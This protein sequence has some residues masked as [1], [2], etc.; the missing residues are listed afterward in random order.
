MPVIE[1]IT[2]ALREREAVFAILIAACIAEPARATVLEYGAD[3]QVTVREHA[4]VTSASPTDD[5]IRMSNAGKERLRTLA[6][7]TALGHAGDD[8][9][10]QA[11]LD[12]ATFALLFEMLIQRESAFDPKAVSPKGARGLGQLMPGTA[13][14][15]GV[16]DPFDPIANLDGS[17]RYLV[18]QLDRFGSVELALAAYNAGPGAVAKHGGVP[19]FAETRAYV[20]WIT[21]RAGIEARQMP[22]AIADGP[23]SADTSVVPSP[24]ATDEREAGSASAPAIGFEDDTTFTRKVSVWEF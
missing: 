6:R 7:A 11:G 9:I 22:V 23:A 21:K 20:D 16:A 4:K 8:A 2:R 13:S 24:S 14:D 5:T 10:E 17:A 15:L 19:P 18:E 3:G 1:A 12:A